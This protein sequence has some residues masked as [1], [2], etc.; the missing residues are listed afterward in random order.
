MVWTWVEMS[1]VSPTN[2]YIAAPCI[3]ARWPP[4]TTCH[5][6]V[7]GLLRDVTAQAESVLLISFPRVAE[8][9]Q[10]PPS[11][12]KARPN[13]RAPSPSWAAWPSPTYGAPMALVPPRASLGSGRVRLVVHRD[14]WGLRHCPWRRRGRLATRVHGD[15][16]HLSGE[17]AG[18][19]STAQSAIVAETRPLGLR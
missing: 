1:T 17:G 6:R 11:H 13:P 4:Q 8:K 19:S 10:A 5:S 3:D 12:R 15:P 16:A 9:S 14:R 2:P 7:V 18:G